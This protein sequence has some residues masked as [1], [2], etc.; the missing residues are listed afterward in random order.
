MISNTN[1]FR[2]FLFSPFCLVKWFSIAKPAE[3]CF[4]LESYQP[5]HESCSFS[6][7]NQFLFN[8][9]KKK[10]FQEKPLIE[11]WRKAATWPARN[12]GR[13]KRRFDWR[14][15]GDA[16]LTSIR[17][18]DHG[19]KPRNRK[20]ENDVLTWI[21][22]QRVAS[23]SSAFRGLISTI[24]SD[25]CE[26]TDGSLKSVKL[27]SEIAGQRSPLSLRENSLAISLI[28]LFL[29]NII[30]AFIVNAKNRH[31]NEKKHNCRLMATSTDQLVSAT[32]EK[33]FKPSGNDRPW[34]WHKR[35]LLSRPDNSNE[36]IFVF[37]IFL[38]SGDTISPLP[39]EI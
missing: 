34:S 13:W 6:V 22:F 20:L 37:F 21:A 24:A 14:N 38:R 30:G 18:K 25:A 33:S 16:L 10:E 19:D 3:T 5:V 1:I 39:R 36:W 31:K 28:C 29:M 17:R 11:N 9:Y 35:P 12:P 4:M 8:F 23:R 15:E 27:Y 2:H 26:M 32:L 7:S